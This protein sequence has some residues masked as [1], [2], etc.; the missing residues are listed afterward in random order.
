MPPDE[1][2]LNKSTENDIIIK[3]NNGGEVS[4]FSNLLQSFQQHH[5]G[6]SM[7]YRHVSPMTHAEH[8]HIPHKMLVYDT[9]A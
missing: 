7:T 9:Y 4:E 2:E 6:S 5:Y 3:N 1:E 8:R